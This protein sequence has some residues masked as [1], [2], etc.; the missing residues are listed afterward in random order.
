MPTMNLT[1]SQ[2]SGV[3]SDDTKKAEQEG[4]D[5]ISR[6]LGS[7]P[8][9]NKLQRVLS[10]VEGFRH[11]NKFN[12]SAGDVASNFAEAILGLIGKSRKISS[13]QRQ[14]IQAI[15]SATLARPLPVLRWSYFVLANL[16]DPGY[17]RS[18]LTCCRRSKWGLAK[19]IQAVVRSKWKELGIPNSPVIMAVGYSGTVD[20][21]IRGLAKASR[22][23][24]LV[25]APEIR[26][27]E[28]QSSEGDFLVSRFK[29]N[30]ERNVTIKTMK[31]DEAF[32]YCRDN[33]IDV[34]LMGTKVI[35]R[36][37]SS[38][39]EIVNSFRCIQFYKEVMS[40]KVTKIIC[41]GLYKIWPVGFYQQNKESTVIA[42]HIENEPVNDILGQE[43]IDW[44]ITE[45]DIVSGASFGATREFKPFFESED[46]EWPCALSACTEKETFKHAV[47][48]YIDM[49]GKMS[50]SHEEGDVSL[51]RHQ[52][53]Y[54]YLE[55]RKLPSQFVR[56]QS[57]YTKM[58]DD[59]EWYDTYKGCFV[60]IMD[61][62]SPEIEVDDSLDAVLK[63]AYRRWGYRPI[64]AAQ[65]AQKEKDSRLILR[66]RVR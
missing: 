57:F 51:Q 55:T 32:A 60:A 46:L 42:P 29:E 28:R 66:P 18:V 3:S 45:L 4:E 63:K 23:A 6:L 1:P 48:Q 39:V 56:A 54:N 53:F 19:R 10:I 5:Y 21:V 16:D 43:H 17:I 41:A 31:V 15:C 13:L 61:E 47:D 65:V 37:D 50:I 22:G 64:F 20:S 36:V 30:P 38:V 58:L 8:N 25:I 49:M 27:P 2:I 26:L 34:M 9:V 59:K 52:E 14:A 62:T 44:I 40:L 33:P 7:C 11:E 24:I 35:G 12:A